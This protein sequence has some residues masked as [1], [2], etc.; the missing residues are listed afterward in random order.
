VKL[1]EQLVRFQGVRFGALGASMG[2]M[3]AGERCSSASR[4]LTDY[5]QVDMLD[6]RY[7][8]VNFGAGTSPGSPN[9]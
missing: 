3:F 9:W 2:G 1:S 5:S 8:S 6:V 7:E 4:G